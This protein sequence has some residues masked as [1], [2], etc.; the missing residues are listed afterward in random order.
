MPGVG[1]VVREPTIVAFAPTSRK[2]LAMGREA[3]R[4]WERG[5]T[6]VQIVHPVRGG[7]VA[8][9]DVTVALLRH[10]ILRAIGRRPWL[11]PQIVT[12]CPSEI[13]PVALRALM[14]SLHAAGGG[15]VVTVLKPLAAALGA[16]LTSNNEETILVIDI[17]GGSTEVAIFSAGLITGARTIPFGGE[18]LDQA[19]RR[20]VRRDGGVRISEAQAEQIKEQI[21][22][23][24]GWSG[25][26]SLSV[27]SSEEEPAEE[28][29]PHDIDAAKV[30]RLLAEAF[31][32]LLNELLWVVETLPRNVQHELT[33]GGV[34]LTGGGAL[35]RGVEELVRNTLHLPVGVATDPASC[36]IL[37]LE[38]VMR[39]LPALALGGKA[40]GA[41]V[42]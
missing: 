29:V 14:D 15:H 7:V 35:L 32:P 10:L 2:P 17:G 33:Q 42:R 30:P 36:T 18:N 27:T 8:D 39:D 40:F 13:T 26:P 23:V 28:P 34:V 31:E 22:S 21:G 41:A 5:V 1:V 9:F 4:L 19:L 24:N 6:D 16:G 37:G 11:P 3:R 20:A 12:S 25:A 38:A